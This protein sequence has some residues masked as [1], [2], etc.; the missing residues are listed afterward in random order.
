M[1]IAELQL[2][3]AVGAY[4]MRQGFIVMSETQFFSKRIDLFAVNRD[5]LATIAIEIKIHDWKRASLQARTYL[6][7]ADQ[8]FVALPSRLA[9]QV[10]RKNFDRENIG[11]LAIQTFETPPETWDIS[12]VIPA[13]ESTYKKNDYVDRLRGDVLFA[14]YD[15]K[16]ES[17]NVI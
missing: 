17:A 11:L 14:R 15:N 1:K 12:T 10:A 16:W 9:H 8:V 3:E 2:Q 7:C 13:P 5:T 6:M 4:L